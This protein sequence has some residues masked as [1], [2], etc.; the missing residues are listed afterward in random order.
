MPRFL[1]LPALALVA[2]CAS[3]SAAQQPT[4]VAS[5]PVIPPASEVAAALQRKY[6][7]IKDFSASF[8]QTEE[9]GVLRR[10]TTESGVVYIKKPG[11]MRFDYTTP[12]KKLFVSDGRTIYMYFPADKQVIRNPVPEQDQATS[13]VQFL[14]GK[15]DVTRDF[16]IRY[17]DTSR[18]DAYV[19]RLDPRM[20][21]AEY[22]WLQIAADKKTYQIRSL[23]AGNAQGGTSTF[24]FSNFKENAG[25][26]DNLFQF[27]IP[28]GTEVI[29]SGKTP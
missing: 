20:R 23:T 29:T 15:G 9:S 25:L 12:Q 24:T 18:E 26:A 16:T 27:S 14:L 22:D 13:A 19:L 28:R 3:T 10:K 6:D 11:K 2:V 4:E 7:G 21:Q 8:S 17:A 5:A 1:T